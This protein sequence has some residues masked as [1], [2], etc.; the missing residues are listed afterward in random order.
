MNIGDKIFELR[1]SM[2]MT[3]Q[4]FADAT[5]ISQSAINFWENGK[6]HPRFEQLRKISQAFKFPLSDF[7]EDDLYAAA[8]TQ[9]PGYEEE[10][11][12]QKISEILNNNHLNDHEKQSQIEELDVKIQIIQNMHKEQAEGAAKWILKKLFEQLNLDGQEKALEQIELLTK[13]PEYQRKEEND[14]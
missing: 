7:I 4:Q 10:I 5:G 9:E 11:I 2:Q 6:R 1:K 12:D 14:V 13:I 3:Q 8:T